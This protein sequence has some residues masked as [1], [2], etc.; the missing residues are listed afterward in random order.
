[1]YEEKDR[2]RELICRARAG[3]AEAREA[4]VCENM[5]LVR[6]CLRMFLGRGTEPEDLFQIGC[7]GLIKAIDRFDLNQEVCFST[8]AVPMILGEIRRFLRDDG[9]IKVS[10]SLREKGFR[11]EKERE[12]FTQQWGREPTVL[13]LSEATGLDPQE[14]NLAWEANLG[15]ASLSQLLSPEGKQERLETMDGRRLRETL[16][17]GNDA[18]L[19]A[20][21]TNHVFLEG[22][23]RELDE[24][25]RRLILL[26]YFQERTQVEAAK[27]LNMSQ[28]GV[29]RMEKK[30]LKKMRALGGYAHKN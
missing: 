18:E 10:R 30:I 7:I 13:E 6:R 11:I 12:R 20:Y 3:E 14:I 16:K 17:Y 15:V 9:M 8:Y 27:E 28:V 23:L 4:L 2:Q 5:G 1:M 22:I 24:M 26:R 25:E 21:V 19:D 29:S